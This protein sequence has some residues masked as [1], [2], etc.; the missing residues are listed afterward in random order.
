MAGGYGERFWPRSRKSTPKQTLSIVSEKPLIQETV[1]RF[2]PLIG[3]SNIYI[4]T[5]EHLYETIQRVV[6][7][8]NFILEPMRRDSAAAIGLA[9]ITIEKK[10]PNATLIVV[11]ADYY[12]K[13][14]M[15][16]QKHLRF[17]T[18]LAQEDRI[19]T[20]GI[21]PTRPA[22]GFGY[23][24]MEE[25]IAQ[26]QG[27]RAYKV[28]KFVEKPRLDIAKQ[29]IES[30]E[31]QWNSGMFVFRIP[32]ILKA[33]KTYMP[34]LYT[35]LEAIRSANFNKK[36]IY[37]NFE[38]LQR[39]SIDYGIMEKTKDIIMVQ[40]KF[41]W[42]DLG[43]WR[44]LERCASPDKYGNILRGKSKIINLDTENCIFDATGP[45]V[46]TLGLSDM[47]VAVTKDVVFLCPKDRAQEVKRIV[48]LIQKEDPE[49]FK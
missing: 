29:Y 31:Y 30:G 23:I 9:A 42:D 34:K 21:E 6:P 2:E 1:E 17:A 38:K 26:S 3:Q 40:G 45:T 5:G 39:I 41:H 33:F 25:E 49:L 24:H 16:Y 35:A 28:Q 44:S 12:I 18:E 47:V 27:I 22:T 48:A 7:D 32:V 8:V 4:I 20:I 36:A 43:D 19:I 37:E 14:K 13:D 15:K 11:G 46:V 10:D